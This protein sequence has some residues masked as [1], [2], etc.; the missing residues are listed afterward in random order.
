MRYRSPNNRTTQKTF[1]KNDRKV[2]GM[3]TVIA[4]INYLI[5]TH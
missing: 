1:T 2:K 5:Q 3:L 4:N